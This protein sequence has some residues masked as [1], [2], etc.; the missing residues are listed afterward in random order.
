MTKL[1]RQLKVIADDEASKFGAKVIWLDAG[2][3]W[4]FEV[5]MCGQRRVIGFSTTPHSGDNAC[6][7]IR[8]DIRRKVADMRICK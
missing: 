7:W 4:R 8:Q 3:H 2:K 5:L 1:L 6:H